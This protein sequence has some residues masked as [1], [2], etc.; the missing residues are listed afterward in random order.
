MLA[1]G[2]EPLGVAYPSRS[3]ATAFH[4]G[5]GRLR[6]SQCSTMTAPKPIA[7]KPSASQVCAFQSDGHT[8]E[9]LTSR[10]L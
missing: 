3:Q 6:E 8:G 9:E 7:S 1:L 10:S 4:P 5:I 2:N